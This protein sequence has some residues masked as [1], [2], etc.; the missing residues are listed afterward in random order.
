MYLFILVSPIT[1][2]G[3]K[4]NSFYPTAL[5]GCRGI[6]FTHGVRMGRCPGGRSGKSLSGAVSQ[7]TIS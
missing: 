7:K 3:L 4:I 6:V 2:G 1:F 5:K